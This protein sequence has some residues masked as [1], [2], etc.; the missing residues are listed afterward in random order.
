MSFQQ[1]KEPVPLM[2]RS[3]ILGEQ[4]NNDFVDV[5][6]G[7]G[8]CGDS[9]YAITRSGLLCEFNHRRLLEKWVELRVRKDFEMFLL[10]QWFNPLLHYF[11]NILGKVSRSTCNKSCNF[12]I[13][14]IYF[15]IYY[16]F[17]TIKISISCDY[18]RC[19]TRRN[20]KIITCN[21]NRYIWLIR[22]FIQNFLNFNTTNS[23]LCC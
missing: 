22:I 21:V 17:F 4:R 16:N 8:Q 11:L 15:I 9:T 13:Y 12:L 2:G 10:M 6:C 3:A 23:K 18:E 20:I 7:R 1:F 5:C 14:Y 19:P